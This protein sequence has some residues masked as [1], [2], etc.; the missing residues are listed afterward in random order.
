MTPIMISCNLNA[1]NPSPKTRCLTSLGH[2]LTVSSTASSNRYRAQE[3]GPLDIVGVGC[4]FVVGDDPR[5]A[6]NELN[7]FH[8]LESVI[9]QLASSLPG[10]TDAAGMLSKARLHRVVGD[11]TTF[12]V[13]T[14]CTSADLYVDS[15]YL[16]ETIEL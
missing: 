7:S 8:P 4:G 10:A 6:R 3:Q 2:G 15:T 12:N 13:V 11:A 1:H 9:T 5:Y 16:K 14:P